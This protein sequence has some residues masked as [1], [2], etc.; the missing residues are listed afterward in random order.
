[1]DFLRFLAFFLSA[2]SA[3]SLIFSFQ[4][5]AAKTWTD[6]ADSAS[7][8]GSALNS[9]AGEEFGARADYGLGMPVK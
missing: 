9:G 6:S 7:V 3:E 4:C 5:K 1:M 2:G 8:P